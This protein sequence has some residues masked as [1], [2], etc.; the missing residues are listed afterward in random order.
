MEE[1]NHTGVPSSDE[2]KKKLKKQA[3]RE[4]KAMRVAE[5][6]H[7]ELQKAEKKQAKT[8]QRLQEQ[9]SLVQE[10][11]T[12]LEAIRSTRRALQAELA[13]DAEAR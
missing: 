10:S 4:A 11:A 8:S 9:Q 1:T 3:K 13:L 6:A 5:Q 12:R 7:R 2:L